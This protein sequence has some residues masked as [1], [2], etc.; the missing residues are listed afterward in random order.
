MDE[1]ERRSNDLIE[2]VRKVDHL[3]GALFGSLLVTESN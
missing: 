3:S 2:S 1:K